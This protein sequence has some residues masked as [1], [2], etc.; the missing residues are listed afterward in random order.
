MYLKTNTKVL[1]SELVFVRQKLSRQPDFFLH[2]Q[3]MRKSHRLSLH[4]NEAM[5]R[6]AMWQIF[7]Q[8]SEGD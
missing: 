6:F 4:I 7:T 8:N 3:D 2:T 5:N 1:F